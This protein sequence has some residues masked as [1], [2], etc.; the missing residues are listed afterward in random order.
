LTDFAKLRAQ[1]EKYKQL[2]G[3]EIDLAPIEEWMMSKLGVKRIVTG[4]ESTRR[5]ARDP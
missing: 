5:K 3:N 1:L 4:K 2:G